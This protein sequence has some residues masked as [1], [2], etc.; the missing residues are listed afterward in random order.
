MHGECIK[1]QEWW[2][3]CNIE[4]QRKC[5]KDGRKWFVVFMIRY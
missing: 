3:V 1:V 2:M 4:E 5:E